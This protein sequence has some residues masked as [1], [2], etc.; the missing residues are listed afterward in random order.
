MSLKIQHLLP[1]LGVLSLAACAGEQNESSASVSQC[2]SAGVAVTDAWAREASAAGASAAYFEIC[3]GGDSAD[4]LVGAS[5]AGAAAT[6]IHETVTD[7]DGVMSMAPV[8]RVE[9]PAGGSATLKPGGAHVMLMGLTEDMA[10]E[11]TVELTLTFENAE[12][13]TVSLD[14]RSLADAATH[15]GH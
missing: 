10:A 11:D 13:L 2:D 7:A 9:L 12:P 8:A 1:I 5:F 3:N 6:E 15:S 14:V 4:A